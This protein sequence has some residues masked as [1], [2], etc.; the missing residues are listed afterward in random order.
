M[1][2]SER[3]EVPFLPKFI[4]VKTGMSVETWMKLVEDGM[5]TTVTKNI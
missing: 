1:I 4:K 3:E 2:S 5:I